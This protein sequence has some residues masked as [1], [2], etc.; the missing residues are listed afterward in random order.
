MKLY[1]EGDFLHFLVLHEIFIAL[2][3]IAIF[4]PGRDNHNT[5]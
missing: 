5:R 2:S 4:I 3:N 1:I